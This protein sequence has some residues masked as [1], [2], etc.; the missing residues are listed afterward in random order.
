MHRVLRI[1]LAVAFTLLSMGPVRLAAAQKGKAA[2][3]D[4]RYDLLAA[5]IAELQAQLRAQQELIEKLGADVAAQREI[6]AAQR[7]ILQERDTPGLRLA[8]FTTTSA[9]APAAHVDPQSGSASG[10]PTAQD[11]QN[12]TTKV[13]ELGK[14]LDSATT[15]L[16]GFKFS[17]DF[18]FRL[19]S[20]TRTGNDIAAPLQ[21]V[22]SRYRVRLNADKEVDPRFKFHL[23]LSTGPANVGTTNDQDMAGTTVKHPF[24]IAE[25]Y[26]DF[27][28]NSHFSIR[29]GRMEEVFA[30]NMRFLW[31]DDVRFN[32]FQQV[33]TVPLSGNTAGFKSVEFRAGEYILSNPNIAVLPASSPFVAAGFPLGQKVR[34]AA[35]FHPGFLLKQDIRKGWTQQ[36]GGDFQYY[37]N[38]NEIQLASTAN[39]FPVLINGALG[40]ALSGPLSASGNATTTAGGAIFTASNFQIV[41]AQYRIQ[42]NGILVGKREMPLYFD[43]Q[44]ARNTG[45]P[46]L[47]D[48]LMG[49][50]NF[51]SIKNRG[52]VRFLYQYGV[53]QANSMISQF[54]DDDF[55]TGTGVNIRVHAIR[56]D[57]ALTRFLQWQN[58]LF[59]QSELSKNDP[60]RQFFVPLQ[61]G[62]NRTLRYLGQLSFTF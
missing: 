18:R 26:V 57:I 3:E 25:A 34:D 36:Y 51:G 16:G 30:D 38:P 41:R 31:D 50:V 11:L 6:L 49:S 21:N 28:P 7:E 60:A 1:T 48:A 42:D 24:S 5:T 32:G 23:Q 45:S 13:D 19:D 56:G 58:L 44:V 35:L 40:V 22:R 17:G 62:A 39:G 14:K 29:G 2:K 12:Y 53:K 52:D 55:G 10:S 46:F 61:A 4:A 59:V 33:F 9:P 37:R 43:I 8:S 47:R 54:T 15:N 27:H 20:Q